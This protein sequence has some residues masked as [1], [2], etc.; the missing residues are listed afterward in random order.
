MPQTFNAGSAPPGYTI[1]RDA[2]QRSLQQA[3]SFPDLFNNAAGQNKTSQ[4]A[5]QPVPQ[6]QQSP[7]QQA[8]P[9]TQPVPPGT[10]PQ[11]ALL[12][13]QIILSK[14]SGNQSFGPGNRPNDFAGS[15]L[16]Q[17]QPGY[18]K[19]FD[20]IANLIIRNKSGGTSPMPAPDRSNFSN[21]A[22]YI[23]SLLSGRT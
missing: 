20:P 22:A 21:A 18:D 19:R 15:L 13:Q 23:I 10:V 5:D 4:A 6:V 1:I 17:Q 3:N 9:P 14:L 8:A 7:T 16:W 12:A 11:A 2:Y